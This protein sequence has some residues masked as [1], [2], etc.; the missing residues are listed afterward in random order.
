MIFVVLKFIS[1]NFS[2]E[3]VFVNE[4]YGRNLIISRLLVDN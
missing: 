1:T 4:T 2:D 3:I